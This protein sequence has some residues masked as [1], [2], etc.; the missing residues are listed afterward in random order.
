MEDVSVGYRTFREGVKACLP[1]V[2]GY[3]GIGIAA[4]VVGKGVG[5]SVLEI[6]AMSVLIYAGSAQFIICGMLAIQ[7]PIV[8]IIATTFLVNLRHFLMSMSVAGYFKNVPLLKSIG[9]GTLLTDESYGVLVTALNNQHKVS[10]AWTNGLNITAYLTWI[11]A[12]GVGGIL[13]NF[14]PN[15]EMLGMDFAL[16]GMFLGLFVLQADLPIRKRTKQTILLLIVVC[17]S[18]FILMKFVS[19]ELAVIIATL[20]GCLVGTVTQNE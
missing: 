5:L 4:G 7:A 13:G 3:V 18:L 14:L 20:L 17:S 8:A 1:T 9:I 15:P 11:L 12:T 6:M 16:T 10:V 19:A 2:L